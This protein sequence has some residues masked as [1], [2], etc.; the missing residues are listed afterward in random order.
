[1]NVFYHVT[2]Y[3]LLHKLFYVVARVFL[4]LL[5]HSKSLLAWGY[6]VAK[7]FWVVARLLLLI[8]EGFFKWVVWL[9]RC[10]Q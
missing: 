3:V 2:C 1:M 10:L 5:R 9:L 8:S 7:V 4:R 6:V